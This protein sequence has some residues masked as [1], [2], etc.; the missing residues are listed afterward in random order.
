MPLFVCLTPDC[1]RVGKAG[2]WASDVW[3]SSSPLCNSYPLFVAKIKKVLDLLCQGKEIGQRRL[4]LSQD[5]SSVA[6][7]VVKFHILAAESGWD[8]TQAV[9]FFRGLSDLVKDELAI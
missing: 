6:K 5:N 2:Q 4:T 3:H 9:F 1:S 7:D 8:D